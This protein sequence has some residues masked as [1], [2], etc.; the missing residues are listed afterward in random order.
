[1]PPDMRYNVIAAAAQNSGLAVLVDWV[2][3]LL[4][5]HQPERQEAVRAD[6]ILTKVEA[7]NVRDIALEHIRAAARDGTLD[8][9]PQLPVI[10]ARWRA[11]GAQEELESWLE[12]R[13]TDDSFVISL[14]EQYVQHTISLGLSDK[15]ARTKPR[16]DL[17][18]VSM[19]VDVNKLLARVEEVVKVER[20]ANARAALQLYIDTATGKISDRD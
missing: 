19:V 13:L 8:A 10:L 2:D 20:G 5:Q 17:K 11:W 18:W 7:E 1:L 3:T 9:V 14:V 16:I 15:A 12:D 4:A 6:P